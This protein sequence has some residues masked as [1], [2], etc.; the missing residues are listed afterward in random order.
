MRWVVA[1][2]ACAGCGR[3]DFTGSA[4]AGNDGSIARDV[5]APPG[6]GLVGAPGDAPTGSIVCGEATCQPVSGSYLSHFS[7][8]GCTGTESYYTPYFSNGNTPNPDGLI[9]SWDG[10]GLAGT[11]YRTVTNY[12]YK[13]MTGTCTDAWP[14]GNT[15]DYFVTIYR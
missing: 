10:N 12:S 3:I 15:L 8:P 11:V 6:D 2:V 5:N 1:V 9:N 13:D 7:A 14:T 4:H